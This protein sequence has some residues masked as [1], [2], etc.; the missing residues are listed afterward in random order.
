MFSA[1]TVRKIAEKNGDHLLVDLKLDPI[2]KPTPADQYEKQCGIRPTTSSSR[3]LADGLVPGQSYAIGSADSDGDAIY[4]DRSS[5]DLGLFGCVFEAWKHHWILRTRPEDWWFPVACK[6]AKGV[7]KA[8]KSSHGGEKVR[9]LF[10]AH[11]GK[12]N[13]AVALNCF[14]IEDA[15]Y[16]YLFSEFSARVREKIKVPEYAQAMQ[17][18]FGTSGPAHKIS[19]QI[20]LMASVQEFF[21]Y[22][23]RCCG[24]GLRGLEMMGSEADW[25]NLAVKLEQV[26]E[27]L[28]PIQYEIGLYGTWWDHVLD[29]F[30][31]LA[32]TRKNPNHP[33]VAKF[34]INI[35]MD[36]T[37]T[38][39]VGGGGS[40]PGK[41]VDVKAYNGWLV[42]FLLDRETILA[43][44]LDERETRE[45]LSGWNQVPMKVSLTWCN[46]PI[47]DTST[48]VAGM[49]GFKLHSGENIPAENENGSTTS[50]DGDE[51]PEAVPSLEPNHLW[52][53]LLPPT[54]PLRN[55]QVHPGGNNGGAA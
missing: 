31:Q 55:S 42:R 38:K 26:R 32:A 22:E 36:T 48:L 5:G 40:M 34:W 49:I 52:A 13:I 30:K 37:G 3:R 4:Y 29:V 24:C 21:S 16:D 46:P 54:S 15:D 53:M 6:I 23:M 19:S 7:D 25:E 11:Q 2:F 27:T 47:S 50:S 14:G 45:A 44:E 18:D 39:W 41:P 43:E 51:V 10:V 9:N 20:N 12:E 35:L 28:K 33:A 8:T 17:S 1:K